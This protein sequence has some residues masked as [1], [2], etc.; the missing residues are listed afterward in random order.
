MLCP[1][2]R[3]LSGLQRNVAR[4]GNLSSLSRFLARAPWE[5]N[6]LME[7]QHARFR[8][9]MAPVVYAR[10]QEEQPTR[11]GRPKAP[12]V[13]RDLIGDDSTMQKEKGRK[14]ESLGTHHSTTHERRVRGQ[15]LVQGLSVLEERRCLLPPRLSRQPPVCEREQVPFQ[16]NSDRMIERLQRVEAV[17]GMLTP[18]LLESGPRAKAIGKAA[19]ERGFLITTDL[20]CNRSL[21]MEMAMTACV[22]GLALT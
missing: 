9:Q 16:S 19:R 13:T 17:A 3:T 14:R 11:R 15:S 10:Q 18:V 20:T 7:R 21:R 22:R 5:T 6:A 4:E 1:Q 2:A 12:M 8:T